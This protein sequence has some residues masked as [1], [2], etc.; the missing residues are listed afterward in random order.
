MPRK[1]QEILYEKEYKFLRILELKNFN[2]TSLMSFCKN[3]IAFAI[4][5]SY[6]MQDLEY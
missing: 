5:Y 1:S 4:G 3:T 2:E 6:K